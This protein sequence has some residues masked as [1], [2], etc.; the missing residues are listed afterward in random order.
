MATV[1]GLPC[2]LAG[3]LKS[4]FALMAILPVLCS[5][6]AMAVAAGG[7]GQPATN[8][9]IWGRYTETV[10]EMTVKVV[11]EDITIRR[12]WAD[13]SW[14]VNRAWRSLT[15]AQ[16]SSGLSIP[17]IVRNGKSYHSTDGALYAYLN[18]RVIRKT[19]SG[20]RWQDREGNW[21][22]Y[23]AAGL[24]QKYGDRNNVSVTIVHDAGGRIAG[25]RDH[26]GSQV[27]WYSYNAD[28]KI[29]SIRDYA[30]R[31]VQYVYDASGRMSEVVDVRGNHWFYTYDA[32]GLLA[33]KKDP[34]GRIT[35]FTYSPEG[36]L[37][38]KK[39]QDGAGFAYEYNYD[40]ARKEF[41]EARTSSAGIVY[42]DWQNDKGEFILRKIGGQTVFKLADSGR[43]KIR[44]DSA[45]NNTT[46]TY[47]EW[48]NLVKEAFADGSV[49]SRTVDHA[50]SLPLTETDENGV[51]TKYTYDPNG[52]LLTRV[53]A[54]GKP[55]A[56]TTSYTYDAAGQQLTA[57]RGSS[58]Y[59]YTYDTYGNVVTVKDPLNN[60]TT[61]TYDVM[62]N[63][64]TAKDARNNIWNYTYDASGN[65]LTEKDPLGNTFTYTY[66]GM[67]NRL[68]SK[69]A[70]NNTTSYVYDIRGRLLTITD[71]AAKQL[72]L[73]YN[74]DGQVTREVDRA[75]KVTSYQYAADGR[76]LNIQD[77][78]TNTIAQ[79]FTQGA[80]G[81]FDAASIQYPTFTQGFAYDKR[82][83]TVTNSSSFAGKT[84]NTRFA[85]DGTGQITDI[86]D[87]NG[88]T[89]RLTYDPLS[90]LIQSVMPSGNIS[91]ITYDDR[92]NPVTFTDAKGSVS[93]F[94]YDAVSRLVSITRPMG[95]KTQFEYDAE[96]NLTAIINARN[97]RRAF[98]YDAAGRLTTETLPA[99]GAGTQAVTI[100]YAYD[101]Q[102]NLTGWSDGAYAASYTYDALD[103]LVSETV[104]YGAFSKTY[105][106]AYEANGYKKSITY[107]DGSVYTYTYDAGN[108]LQ[109]IKVGNAGTI[110]NNSFQWTAPTKTTL[111][112]GTTQSYAYN[113]IFS[114]ESINTLDPASNPLTS[115]GY[116]HDGVQNVLSKTGTGGAS[117]YS[118]DVDERL[119]GAGT[120]S[121]AY[122]QVG[123]LLHTGNANSAWSYNANHELTSRPN[124]TYQYDADGNQI[125]K[126]ENG[127]TTTYAYDAANRLIQVKQGA[128]IIADYAYDPFDRR[129]SKT[130]G[131]NTTH[132]LYA[133]EGLIAEFDGAGAQSVSYGWE[134]DGMWGNH[135]LWQK[136]NTEYY[137]YHHD[138]LGTPVLLT[139]RNGAVAWSAAYDAWG[140]AS[141]TKNTINSN[142]R[143]AGQYFDAETGLHYNFRR[144]YDPSISRYIT[145][146]PIGL[147]GGANL[148]LY[149]DANPVNYVDP[150]GECGLAGAAAGAAIGGG[151][152]ILYDLINGKCVDWENALIGAGIGAV[153]GAVCVPPW[154][155]GLRFGKVKP[156]ATKSGRLFW[157]GQG[158]REAAEAF[159]KANGAKTL[160][161]TATGKVLDKI[162][163]A[164]NFK[165]MKP[166]WNAA[167]KRFAKGAK[168]DVDV[169]HSGKG[170]RV[171]SV[172]AKKEYPILKKQGNDINYHVVE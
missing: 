121:Y 148:Y 117:T 77:G 147:A 138:H 79:Q 141:I 98:G 120:A 4:A 131:T 162:T 57:T 74:N 159:A 7:P 17:A 101:A 139:A 28:G 13:G 106:Y 82:N 145:T 128:T 96:G 58:T 68:T 19:A 90:R 133:D 102:N 83:R 107:P 171:D 43:T 15:F 161:M 73:T 46:E 116:T 86:T 134:P 39:D 158:S 142:L 76:L 150:T 37:L 149:V 115:F 157:S 143:L 152:P 165:Y 85:Y 105:A 1:A 5:A 12:T 114:I 170:V 9:S 137:Y 64:L 49:R 113:G 168:G 111:P 84:L 104:N 126:T 26:T 103:R 53:E 48:D 8:F 169:F 16:Q 30:G 61:Y 140:N 40:E 87:A 44:T 33:S 81:F 3:A 155:K 51:I 144:Y 66:D 63:V 166:L 34:L 94:A 164:G 97:H 91:A 27:I 80:G 10:N 54:F 60:T 22:E 18:R 100:S 55:E 172:W 31:T 118:Y 124:A 123:N 153:A 69:D 132:Y 25:A 56:R 156:S 135:P 89:R 122:D 65:L 11:G 35:A 109:T 154:A 146:D 88:A 36:R 167:S 136:R 50:H 42:E 78:N 32:K 62:G 110:V 24:I 75:G 70:K 92:D 23:D 160:E 38:S 52:N 112:G 93:T 45:G 41:Y 95:E 2:M 99:T 20:Y 29:A 59:S 127:V 14:Q 129:I 47:D 108:R 67:G 130:V 119:T 21:I 151:L 6:A 163:T 72:S 71:A 125:S